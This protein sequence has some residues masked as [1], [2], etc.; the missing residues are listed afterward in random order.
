MESLS[1][2]P[3]AGYAI[4]AV[5]AVLILNKLYTCNLYVLNVWIAQR[6]NNINEKAGFI[7]STKKLYSRFV[8][9]RRHAFTKTLSLKPF[10]Y[11]NKT[12]PTNSPTNSLSSQSFT[13]N[14]KTSSSSSFHSARSPR[15]F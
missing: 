12:L 2:R 1:T 8:Y 5:A 13:Y 14:L 4:C 15:L 9:L 10:S 3:T 7:T 11:T 6:Q